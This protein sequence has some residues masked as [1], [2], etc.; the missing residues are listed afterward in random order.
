[1]VVPK[2]I[3]VVVAAAPHSIT[4]VIVQYD[5]EACVDQCVHGLVK[6]V[7]RCFAHK[8]WVSC[9]CIGTDHWIAGNLLQRVDQADAVKGFV[10]YALSKL[11]DVHQIEAI[12][13]VPLHVSAIQVDTRKSN[14]IA[15]CVYHIG[16][17]CGQR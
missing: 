4:D 11:V 9:E 16:T 2:A 13:D 12:D 5:H 7:H 8:A 17:L 6:D 1:M 15:V 14:W 3:P 10:R